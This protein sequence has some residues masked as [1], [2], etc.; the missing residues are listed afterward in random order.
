M[1]GMSITTVKD[2]VAEI[3]DFDVLEAMMAEEEA[4]RDR[5]GAKT[6]IAARI[7]FLTAAAEEAADE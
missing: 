4:N 2:T 3:T 1:K 6:A 7:E 5:K